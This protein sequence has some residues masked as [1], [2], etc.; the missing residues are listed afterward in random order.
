[1]DYDSKLKIEYNLASTHN[2]VDNKP[3]RDQKTEHSQNEYFHEVR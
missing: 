2:K 1:M 3:L